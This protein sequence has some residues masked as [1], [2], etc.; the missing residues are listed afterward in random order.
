MNAFLE[1][2]LEEKEDGSEQ[3]GVEKAGSCKKT[4]D[5]TTPSFNKDK[6]LFFCRIR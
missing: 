3:T 1:V 5:D 6:S 2:F 4:L